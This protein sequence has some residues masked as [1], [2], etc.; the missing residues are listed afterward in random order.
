MTEIQTSTLYI[1][2][3]ISQST[4]LSSRNTIFTILILSYD[5]CLDSEEIYVLLYLFRHKN[6]FP[7]KNYNFNL[8]NY[9]VI[10]DFKWFIPQSFF[11]Q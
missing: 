11:A 8:V 7:R 2:N 1:Y 9:K 3:A 6:C 10:F 5:S 4:E